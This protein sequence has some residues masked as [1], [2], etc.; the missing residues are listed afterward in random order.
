MVIVPAGSFEMGSNADYENPAHR[1]TIPKQFAIGRYE[2]TFDE[3][4]RCVEEKG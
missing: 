1:V 2:V 4:D 3:W